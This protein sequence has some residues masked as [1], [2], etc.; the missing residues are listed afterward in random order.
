MNLKLMVFVKRVRNCEFSSRGTFLLEL[1]QFRV[2][3]SH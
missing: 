3:L 2:P 1:S